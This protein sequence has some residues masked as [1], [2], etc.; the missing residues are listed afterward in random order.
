MI[1]TLE[2]DECYVKEVTYHMINTRL[3]NQGKFE[4]LVISHANIKG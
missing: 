2:T 1:L 3:S 4:V